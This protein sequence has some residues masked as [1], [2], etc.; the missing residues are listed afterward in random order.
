MSL[1]KAVLLGFTAL[2]F[3]VALFIGAAPGMAFLDMPEFP[4]PIISEDGDKWI[5][6][7]E[8]SHISYTITVEP[9]FTSPTVSNPAKITI[10]A[11]SLD[12]NE[13]VCAFCA[14]FDLFGSSTTY[15][16][17]AT[18]TATLTAYATA[19]GY[20]S[21][22]A[23][24]TDF[25]GNPVTKSMSFQLPQQHCGG[26]TDF[27]LAGTTVTTAANDKNAATDWTLNLKPSKA[28]AVKAGD[29]ITL[30]A[31]G[32]MFHAVS[33]VTCLTGA[34]AGLELSAK[35]IYSNGN[36]DSLEISFTNTAPVT[37]PAT[38]VSLKILNV[39]NPAGTQDLACTTIP[40]VTLNA[41]G[42]TGQIKAPKLIFTDSILSIV[43]SNASVNVNSGG[44]VLEGP[45]TATVSLTDSAG[46]LLDSYQMVEIRVK[47]APA[48][49]IN[50][51]GGSNGYDICCL[52]KGKGIYII[53]NIKDNDIQEGSFTR[54]IEA[55][56]ADNTLMKAEAALTVNY[57][58]TCKITG[59]LVDKN[60]GLPVSGARV[61][62]RDSED[63]S[64]AALYPG[65]DGVFEAMVA[66]GGG[67]GL[68]ITKEDYIDA[69][70]YIY[71]NDFAGGLHDVGSIELE[72]YAFK[73]NITYGYRAA[74]RSGPAEP[75]TPDN[76][77]GPYSDC[78]YLRKGN[79]EVRP[80]KVN[81]HTCYFQEGRG[82]ARGDSVE[83]VL[84]LQN[85]FITKALPLTINA[86]YNAENKVEFVDT[87]KG[88]TVIM[89]DENPPAGQTGDIAGAIYRGSCLVRFEL[90]PG[91][92]FAYGQKR[93]ELDN[94]DYSV[95]VMCKDVGIFLDWSLDQITGRGLVEG[96]DFKKYPLTIADGT[97][98]ALTVSA[99]VSQKRPVL[100]SA[101]STVYAK[102]N[103]NSPLT[104][105]VV[106]FALKDTGY[107][108]THR[109]IIVDLPDGMEFTGEC[110]V[111][112][113]DERSYEVDYQY[114]DARKQLIIS[115]YHAWLFD[116]YSFVITVQVGA[117]AA[118]PLVAS[119][120]YDIDYSGIKTQELIGS[121]EAIA[122][123]I[124][125]S[126][127]SS[128]DNPSVILRGTAPP[129][130]EI[131]IYDGEAK[132]GET[133]SSKA[134]NFEKTVTLNVA[135]YGSTHY[136]TAKTGVG[137]EEQVSPVLEI[138]YQPLLPKI[139]KL[140]YQTPGFGPVELIGP[141]APAR[142][143][144]DWQ[145]DGTMSFA[146]ETSDNSKINKMW[147]VIANGDAYNSGGQPMTVPALYDA[148]KGQ[149]LTG[150]FHGYLNSFNPGPITVH[151][152]LNNY[153]PDP[154]EISP[155]PADYFADPF[156]YSETTLEQYLESQP[157]EIK[158][159]KINIT[160]SSR[161]GFSAGVEL[162]DETR[163][164]LTYAIEAGSPPVTDRPGGVTEEKLAQKGFHKVPLEDGGSAYIR[165]T[166]NNE[167]VNDFIANDRFAALAA[168]SSLDLTTTC[169]VFPVKNKAAPRG[170]S[171]PNMTPASDGGA[172]FTT[173]GVTSV[174]YP[175]PGGQHYS[176]T[177]QSAGAYGETL[178]YKAP[179]RQPDGSY[180]EQ[181]YKFNGMKDGWEPVAPADLPADFAGHNA[182]IPG[183]EM[184]G[185]GANW[186]TSQSDSNANVATVT[187]TTIGITPS[188][189]GNLNGSPW[190]GG[191]NLPG[192]PFKIGTTLMTTDALEAEMSL[193][194]T[195]LNALKHRRYGDG[196]ICYD[197][198]DDVEKIRFNELQR[199]MEDS[200][201]R[202]RDFKEE[203][204]KYNIVTTVVGATL[205][206]LI[207]GGVGAAGGAAAAAEVA[208]VSLFVI[209]AMGTTQCTYNCIVGNQQLDNFRSQVSQFNALNN[210]WARKFYLKC[211]NVYTASTTTNT[212]FKIDPS[213][214]AYEGMLSNAVA[215]AR[216]ELW[217]A[218]N[219]K[220]ANARVWSEAADYDELNPQTTPATGWYQWDVPPGW[221]QVR[222]FKE[223]YEQCRSEWLPVPP[224][225]LGVNLAMISKTAPAATIT[226]DRAAMKW[227]IEFSKPM[228]VDTVKAALSLTGGRVTESNP[229]VIDIAALSP[230]N[231]LAM[232]F[233]VFPK[234][235]DMLPE[236][237]YNLTLA[238]SALSYAGAALDRTYTNTVT[239]NQY[240]LWT[241][242]G[243]FNE[244][245]AG[246]V[247]TIR[248][249]CP[250]DTNT[251]TAQNVTVYDQDFKK[252]NITVT[253]G[254]DDQS[255]LVNPPTGGYQNGQTYTM[256]ISGIKSAN[257]K[258]LKNSYKMQFAVG[259]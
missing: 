1:K 241:V 253:P 201:Q 95:V 19:P 32:A 240:V 83:A 60:T 101:G 88:F 203:Y 252:A 103:F 42:K 9:A 54:T 134:G 43:L 150:P 243:P 115:P 238:A 106:K 191:A 248:F 227:K 170:S 232:V 205:P 44:K 127:P 117:Q 86:D 6:Y 256:Y 148:A 22:G 214:Y 48:T 75:V 141:N 73:V 102:P 45:L 20:Y 17:P 136:L 177:G 99:P 164:Q 200:L 196:T 186:P 212:G 161:S 15:G 247:W 30:Q 193:Q 160:R 204:D 153:V 91:Q 245:P 87:E 226:F 218:G 66:A 146:V 111:Y 110:G 206:G 130:A 108:V 53:K 158:N 183:S 216:A 228:L 33:G 219:D 169:Y 100:D 39:V 140:L 7:D 233:E 194:I 27:N 237:T 217:L 84:R 156:K 139:T 107:P 59:K 174:Y 24:S 104:P 222:L 64:Y 251:I 220:G 21:L 69:T 244:I 90:A 168:D 52:S 132:I 25:Y 199:D 166:I 113:T 34:G 176:Y 56:L 187:N 171:P 124:R 3:A 259:K 85:T 165:Q 13:V 119:L 135:P 89:A 249:N 138:V 77:Y 143:C 55:R 209:G 38:G 202:L 78:P 76:Y 31:D 67:V 208:P 257:G 225:Q 129:Q 192:L 128:T 14:G 63:N 97:I 82:I 12:E 125:L 142:L 131:I 180:K 28:I 254:S 155:L 47:N 185:M 96:V 195:T 105:F 4:D 93:S 236:S 49:L 229:T 65:N 11:T 145:V 182:A 62:V 172:Y 5:C 235:G 16:A 198:L 137:A 40:V 120:E 184:T 190:V 41:S 29:K 133:S 255:I 258:H 189:A 74:T 36:P 71:E 92:V 80:K 118:G 116:L 162:A 79:I 188:V 70:H 18:P 144:T 234:N 197:L 61:D 10:E 57:Q 98:A 207:S 157:P 109:R 242:S 46:N 68:R 123:P 35:C 151:F 26:S 122:Q 37:I 94:G 112:N 154:V 246:K 167:E 211:G 224:P 8:D 50:G 223:G 221:W 152:T 149:W 181:F 230:E 210:A 2:V 163:S 179:A 126:G 23:K 178:Y 121:A 173:G 250:V 239:D 231:E 147:V 81:G 159:A 114:D 213:G 51:I 58:P 72:H 175:P 215:G